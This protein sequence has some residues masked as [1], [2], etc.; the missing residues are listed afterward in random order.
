MWPAV[1]VITDAV[2]Q[3]FPEVT[4]VDI[5]QQPQILSPF[6]LVFALR[7]TGL[8]FGDATSDDRVSRDIVRALQRCV[9][10]GPAS[11]TDDIAFDV[12]G[13]RPLLPRNEKTHSDTLRRRLSFGQRGALMADQADAISSIGTSVQVKLSFGARGD[14]PDLCSAG[15]AVDGKGGCRVCGAGT[16][17]FAGDDPAGLRSTPCDDCA[18]SAS[19]LTDTHGVLLA[20]PYW[21]ATRGGMYSVLPCQGGHPAGM[22]SSASWMYTGTVKRRCVQGVLEPMDPEESCVPMGCSQVL[23]DK[24][25]ADADQNIMLGPWPASDHGGEST[26]DC[27][28]RAGP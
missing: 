26:I 24:A 17:N 19:N 14:A 6:T 27:A 21:P 23:S 10:L 25:G 28:S 1:A 18:A 9:S 22:N 13:M 4:H 3:L 20:H 8:L 15:Y 7:L 16:F 12:T 2:R 5:D 11:S